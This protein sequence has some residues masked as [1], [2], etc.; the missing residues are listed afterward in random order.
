MKGSFSRKKG[1]KKRER[2]KKRKILRDFLFFIG[3]QV[4][5]NNN[6]IK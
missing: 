6:V 1:G 5:D 4:R 3:T 2:E